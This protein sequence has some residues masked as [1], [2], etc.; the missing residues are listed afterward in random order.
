VLID[1]GYL[2]QFPTNPFT[3]KPMEHI[4]IGQL[5]KPDCFTYYAQPLDETISLALDYAGYGL[6]AYGRRR[7]GPRTPLETFG[8]FPEL[9]IDGNKVIV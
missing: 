8:A 2:A 3:G 9:N 7:S 1:E 5:S 4:E 6:V